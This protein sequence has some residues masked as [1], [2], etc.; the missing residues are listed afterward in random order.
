MRIYRFDS[1]F[2]AF[3]FVLFTSGGRARSEL[4]PVDEVIFYFVSEAFLFDVGTRCGDCKT[5]A[6]SFR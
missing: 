4:L 2:R 1:R 5:H 3:R 6:F